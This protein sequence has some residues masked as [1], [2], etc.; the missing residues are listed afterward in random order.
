MNLDAIVKLASQAYSGDSAKADVAILTRFSRRITNPQYER[1]VAWCAQRMR[2]LHF[3]EVETLAF[4]SDGRRFYGG[5]KSPPV[6]NVT[7]ARLRLKLDGRWHTLANYARIPTSVFPYSAPTSGEIRTR[8]VPV[9]TP[10]SRGA[11]VFSEALREPPRTLADQGALGV[12]SDFSPN[13]SGVREPRDF[14]DGHRWENAYLLEDTAGLV[15][16]SLS[17]RQGARVRRAL[18]RHG[19]IEAAFAVA[20]SR[21]PGHLLC[22]TGVLRGTEKPDEEVVVVAHLYEPGANDNNSGVAGAIEALRTIRR[23]VAQGDL[24]PPQ[25]TIRVVFTFEIVGFL[26]YFEAVRNR[27]KTYVAG[28]NPDM[29]GQNQKLCRSTLHVYRAPDAVAS[30]ADPLLRHCV[31]KIV[32]SRLAVQPMGFIVNDNIVGDPTVG[33]PC[34]ALIH[35]RDRYYHSNEDTPDKVSALTLKLVGGAMT[36]YLYA[37]AALDGDLAR[38]IAVLCADE[39]E[40]SLRRPDSPP[41]RIRYRL[42]CELAR[43][44]RLETLTGLRCAAQRRRLRTVARA[45][46]AATPAAVPPP[47]R[48][49]RPL[50]QRARALVPVRTLAGPLTLQ[51]IPPASRGRAP[52]DPT[53][54]PQLLLPLFWCDGRRTLLDVYRCQ[55]HETDRPLSLAKLLEYFDFLEKEKFVRLRKAAP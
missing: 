33:P 22:A 40:R 52:F 43:L 19:A 35:L 46:I 29:I 10:Q 53:W 5:W 28:V 44:A 54:S 32:G 8:L 7:Q 38:E 18:Q 30:F 34:P 55:L 1:S 17:R 27:N 2:N 36:A 31:A 26:A 4:P 15:G 13:W 3:D 25:R 6:W 42:S 37:A 21:G 48:L 41:S 47:E 11:L 49:P 51:H 20:G 24:P 12:V 14:Q 50:A 45:Q 16:F 23:L 39:G 9:G